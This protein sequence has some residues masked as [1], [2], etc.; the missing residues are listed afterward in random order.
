M[1]NGDG[2]SLEVSKMH[3]SASSISEKNKNSVAVHKPSR[4]ETALVEAQRDLEN[5]D[6]HL[7]LLFHPLRDIVMKPALGIATHVL[8]PVAVIPFADELT[9][10]WLNIPFSLA[11][12][13][14]HA[15]HSEQAT[16]QWKTRQ[17]AL[18][19]FQEF[20]NT[21]SADEITKEKVALQSFQGFIISAT[22]ELVSD[23]ACSLSQW[24][25]YTRRLIGYIVSTGIGDGLSQTINSDRYLLNVRI[26]GNIMASDDSSQI[27]RIKTAIPDETFNVSPKVVA[28]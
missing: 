8:P 26:L 1:M 23:P 4:I 15:T 14:Y 27:R 5:A 2:G 11:R 10:F 9:A 17:A 18:H 3:R 22:I 25:E 6:F 16:A 13:A 21:K 12:R 20:A 19:G 28:K 24:M 7:G